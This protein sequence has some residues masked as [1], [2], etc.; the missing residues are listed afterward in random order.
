M[1]ELHEY[2]ELPLPFS[3][4][5]LKIPPYPS[6]KCGDQLQQHLLLD[7]A[8]IEHKNNPCHKQISFFHNIVWRDRAFVDRMAHHF[9]IPHYQHHIELKK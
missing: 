3:H 4:R 1:D 5:S 9:Y 6:N 2:I 7:R 8:D